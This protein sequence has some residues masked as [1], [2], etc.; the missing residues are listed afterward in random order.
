MNTETIHQ[1][2]EI[3]G[4]RLNRKIGRGGYGD[5]WEA[6][7]PGGLKKAIK[8]IF[9]FSD[10]KRAQSELKALD[11]IKEARHPFLCSLERIEVFNSRLV[12][13]SEL[14]DESLAD[15]FNKFVRN[16]ESGIPRDELIEYM[17]ETADALDYLNNKFGL[18]HLD[19]KPENI[20]LLSGHAKVA[21][22]GLVKDLTDQSQSLMN[23]M[24]PMYAAPELF[25]GSPC[26]AS[27]Q[28]SLATVYQEMLTMQRPF[29]GTTPAQLAAQH[30]HGKPDLRSLPISD[31]PVVA[32]ALSKDPADRYKSCSQFV[33][34]LAN[35]KTRKRVIKSRANV[36]DNVETN[37]ETVVFDTP[38]SESSRSKQ[39]TELF[40]DSGLTFNKVDL[41]SK[42]PP[43]CEPSQTKFQ[44]TIVIGVG[45]S[46]NTVL[47]KTKQRLVAR[48]GCIENIPS[49]RLLC[50]DSDRSALAKMSIGGN[51]A[52]INVNETLAIP[53]RRSDQY[54]Q[55]KNLD[56][57][58]ISRRWI[59]N[60][61]RSLQTEGLR[62]LGRLAFVDHFEAICSKLTD[63]IKSVVQT[64]QIAAS[65]ETLGLNPSEQVCPRIYLLGNICGGLSSGM[66]NDMA[67]TVRLMLAEQGIIS[68][69]LLGI[70]MFGNESLGREPGLATANAYS[71]LA[72]LRHFA[73]G[74]YPG[75]PRI[76]IPEF[77]DELPFDHAYTIRLSADKGNPEAS[78]QEKI[79]E[80]IC[81]STTTQCGDFFDA[82][83]K[84]DKDNEEFGFRSFGISVCGP[85]LQAIG[86]DAV[87][88]I[89]RSLIDRWIQTAPFQQDHVEQ[90]VDQCSDKYS[91]N[92][93]QCTQAV[94]SHISELPEWNQAQNSLSESSTLSSPNQ[95]LDFNQANQFF[96]TIYGAAHWSRQCNE[97][98]S[99][100]SEAADLEICTEAQIAGDHLSTVILHLL[101][102][103]QINFP[104]LNAVQSAVSQMLMTEQENVT[105]G[106]EALSAQTREL[107][108]ELQEL[109][110]KLSASQRLEQEAVLLQQLREIRAE[111]F[112]L[113]CCENHYKTLN[114]SV[115]SATETTHRLQLQLQ[116]VGQQFDHKPVEKRSA[117]YT[118]KFQ[119][120]LVDSVEENDE[121]L[122]VAIEQLVLEEI[123]QTQGVLE[124]LSDSVRWQHALPASIRDASAAVLA[125]AFRKI[126]VD[127]VLSKNNIQPTALKAWL[128]E[129]LNEA[130]PFV[131][132]CGGSATLLLGLPRY[133]GDSAL[134]QTINDCFELES[135]SAY[136]TTGD[137]VMC[138]EAERILLANLA[139]S[140][141]KDA[142][143]ATEIVKRIS[144][145]T[146]ILWTSLEDLM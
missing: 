75:D 2:D 39:H 17:R 21:D 107:K 78:D 35:R 41:V 98:T 125:D 16:N 38:V 13:V 121:E 3:L 85:G 113:R 15:L 69:E 7:A 142:P 66:L 47:Q 81:L 53:L 117:R 102:A 68:S 14:A 43:Q 105:N 86:R 71:Y 11:R 130:T 23:G 30:M 45:N 70:L 55:K 20:L 49:L 122:M 96:D 118:P 44:P 60:V 9:G 25:D 124:F 37:R 144:S 132:D 64:N 56:L 51:K 104:F 141:L 95:P 18:Q 138:F 61:P 36:R 143:E 82:S 72:E 119:Q 108:N 48:H 62:P 109:P 26:T 123:N 6:E 133:S 94:M 136:A 110:V 54:R 42:A 33:E 134:P 140:I 58:W 100:L 146:D 10:G 128:N 77:D 24:T 129:Q 127:D 83:R 92:L 73:D 1:E 29:P 5:V 8:I 50:I 12:I 114:R 137:F 112:T 32:K 31:Q 57:S 93:E 131:T 28:Y 40:S 145:R 89:S 59:Y 126:S 90:F 27:D 116:A 115:N 135:K 22:F 80:Y 120:M 88:R 76:G 139:F 46:A 106:L 97:E 91:I 63:V 99:P 4:Y 84:L 52:A 74:G 34:Q 87:E 65:C 79:A 103:N 111:E 19:I 101:N 67:Y